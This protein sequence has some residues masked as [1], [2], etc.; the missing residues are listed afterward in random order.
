MSDKAPKGPLQ[1]S[2]DQFEVSVDMAASNNQRLSRAQRR[3]ARR[4]TDLMTPQLL[5][6]YAREDKHTVQ[7]M[8]LLSVPLA[9]PAPINDRPTKRLDAVV[10]PP[11]H[12]S[13]E[14][15]RETRIQLSRQRKPLLALVLA[16][17][18]VVGIVGGIA[19][20]VLIFGDHG[21]KAEPGA[22]TSKI[23]P[24][25]R[26]QE[27]ARLKEPP[28]LPPVSDSEVVEVT[29]NQQKR[30]IGARMREQ[31]KAE[32]AAQPPPAPKTPK[33]PAAND[34]QLVD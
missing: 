21:A 28:P 30:A 4:Q 17:S 29:D 33:E 31:K 27:P 19:V 34:Y 2:D 9:E 25:P 7:D 8:E 1:S 11:V 12:T 16:I 5:E 6:Q 13:I 22:A 26:E 15:S 23:P 18:C 10:G 24:L 20:G 32:K 14:A 3:A